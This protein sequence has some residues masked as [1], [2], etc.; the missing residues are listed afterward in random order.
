MTSVFDN[1]LVINVFLSRSAELLVINY[2]GELKNYLV[3]FVCCIT[4]KRLRGIF[5]R[6]E[7]CPLFLM[8]EKHF[9]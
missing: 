6:K 4:I 2:C 8:S 9:Y 3:R 5:L 7:A 1:E